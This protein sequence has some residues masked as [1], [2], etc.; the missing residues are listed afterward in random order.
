M[1]AVLSVARNDGCSSLLPI[2]FSLAGGGEAKSSYMRSS[3]GKLQS[4]RRVPVV[5]LR[6]V[7]EK[8]LGGRHVSFV[9]VDAQGYDLD[10]IRSAGMS[11]AARSGTVQLEVTAD[12]C[13]LPYAL[14]T[15]V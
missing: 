8:W 10:V 5:P 4:T 11:A 1:L 2:N 6:I 15:L 3:C 12:R 9:K 14:S 7:I 13:H